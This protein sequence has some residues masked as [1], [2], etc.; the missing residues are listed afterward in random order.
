MAATS[1]STVVGAM[2]PFTAWPAMNGPSNSAP[3]HAP[4]LALSL[5]AAHTRSSGAARSTVLVM[6]SV[7]IVIVSSRCGI[8]NLQVAL[9]GEK[10]QPQGCLISCGICRTTCVLVPVEAIGRNSHPPAT[11]ATRAPVAND[12]NGC[13]C[14]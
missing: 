7:E 5:I 12:I 2:R 13:G 4:N 9:T 8:G 1:G 3:N 6:L 10:A 14:V 11:F